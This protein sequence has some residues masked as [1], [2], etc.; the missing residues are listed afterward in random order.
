MEENSSVAAPPAGAIPALEYRRVSEAPIPEGWT[1]VEIYGYKPEAANDF[2]RRRL[3]SKVITSSAVLFFCVVLFYLQNSVIFLDVRLIG[4]FLGLYTA[5]Q[6]L[7]FW[8]L[9]RRIRDQW[10]TFRVIFGDQ[11]LLRT[12]KGVPDLTIPKD[13]IKTI[14]EGNRGIAIQGRASLH[15]IA[16]PS[17]YIDRFTEL[18]S[19]VATLGD[20]KQVKRSWLIVTRYYTLIFLM[21]G[22]LIALYLVGMSSRVL[23]VE[24]GCLAGFSAMLGWSIIMTWKSP[25]R[26]VSQKIYNLFS[27]V[28]P[29]IMLAK[30]LLIH[31]VIRLPF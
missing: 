12:C 17:L 23:L 25:N 16:L 31:G 10:P 27:L 29:A 2:V 21:V 26:S 20:I 11:G 14:R 28:L 1:N 7:S 15:L 22:G 3:V 19:R 18:R 9:A 5:L 8:R 24:I 30:I 13:Q 4:L 6:A